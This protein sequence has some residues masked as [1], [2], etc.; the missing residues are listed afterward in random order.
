MEVGE[1]SGPTAQM[2]FLVKLK[3]VP[4]IGDKL[5][6]ANGN[7]VALVRDVVGNVDRPFAVVEPTSRAIEL[8]GST[9]LFVKRDKGGG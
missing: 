7:Y 9:R 3:K 2:K 6:D 8:K 4:R 5:C 1:V